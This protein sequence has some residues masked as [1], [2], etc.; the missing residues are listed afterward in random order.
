MYRVSGSSWLK[1]YI[2]GNFVDQK[3][4][5]KWNVTATAADGNTFVKELE[6]TGDYSFSAGKGAAFSAVLTGTIPALPVATALDADGTEPSN[7]YIVP[8]TGSTYSFGAKSKQGFSYP[9][10]YNSSYSA[11]VLWESLPYNN[12][13]A[14]GSVIKNAQLCS[15][16]RIYV[17]TTGT[18]GN[19][20][21]AVLNGEGSVVWSW[22][23]WV[24]DYDPNGSSSDYNYINLDGTEYLQFRGKH[25]RLSRRAGGPLLPV[26]PKRS[27]CRCKRYLRGISQP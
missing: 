1:Y 5:Y 3:A 19:A 18:E 10:T 24:T 17:E 22:H 25:Q 2:I 8:C 16:N 7:C 15:D 20:L 9:N 13:V 6:F 12:S 14:V 26:R 21:V 23:L 27:L 4:G 11:A